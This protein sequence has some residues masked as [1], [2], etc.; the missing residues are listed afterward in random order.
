M[1]SKTSDSASSMDRILFSV[2][3]AA[4][5][6]CSLCER[7]IRFLAIALFDSRS[8]A[9]TFASACVNPKP[10][11]PSSKLYKTPRLFDKK[12]DDGDQA[13]VVGSVVWPQTC[14]GLSSANLDQP[15]TIRYTITCSGPR[16]CIV[17]ASLGPPDP[18]GSPGISRRWRDLHE[19]QT[20]A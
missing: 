9:L 15:D 2:A 16:K 3:P 7:R 13:A 5:A 11:E 20:V 18:Q 12:Q 1:C 19:H 10:V 8:P 14:K 6:G 4:A 17:C